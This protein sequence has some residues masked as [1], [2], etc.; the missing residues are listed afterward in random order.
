[1][2]CEDELDADGNISRVA[3][4][5]EVQLTGTLIREPIYR[6][7]W[8]EMQYNFSNWITFLSEKDVVGTIKSVETGT[9]S[10]DSDA[11]TQLGG[12]WEEQGTD[13]LGTVSITVYKK[14]AL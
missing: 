7:Y 3:P 12:T 9:F 6:L 11:S 10:D 8:N 4:P 1:M 14:T 13:T 2:W 5:A